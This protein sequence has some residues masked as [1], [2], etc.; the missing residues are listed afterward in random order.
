MGKKTVAAAF[1]LTNS[2]TNAKP[3]I[4]FDGVFYRYDPYP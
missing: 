3:C 1:H 4:E 2:Q